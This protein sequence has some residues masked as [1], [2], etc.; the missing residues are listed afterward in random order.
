MRESKT[1]KKTT[2]IEG[3]QMDF[4]RRLPAIFIVLTVMLQSL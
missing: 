2:R 4:L 1:L 3:M